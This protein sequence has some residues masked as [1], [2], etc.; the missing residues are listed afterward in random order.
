MVNKQVA[1]IIFLRKQNLNVRKD[2]S[3]FAYGVVPNFRF[4]FSQELAA[5]GDDEEPEKLLKKRRI[6]QNLERFLSNSE[7]V[8]PKGRRINS[9][10][11]FLPDDD[12]EN[13][14]TEWSTAHGQKNVK[15]LR[16][17]RSCGISNTIDYAS[18]FLFPLSFALFNY[19]YWSHYL[20]K[21]H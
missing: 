3:V 21:Q 4:L 19:Y 9:K 16:R 14:M 20:T 10:M 11:P 8:I 17:C 18:R 12:A 15:V 6:L 5:N 2:Q 13:R 1:A 7:P